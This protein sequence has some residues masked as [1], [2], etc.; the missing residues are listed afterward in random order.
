MSRS[1]CLLVVIVLCGI[2]VGCIPVPKKTVAHYG[3]E[4]RLTD[5]ATGAPIAKSRVSI[6]VDG[7]EFKKKTNPR[8]EF[9]VAFDMHHFCT[10]LGGP[11]WADATRA[12]VDIAIDGYTPYQRTFVVRSESLDVPLPPDQGRL[13]ES[14]VMLGEIEMKRREQV[15]APS[16]APLRR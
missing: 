13:K 16:V 1:T 9:K 12:A 15:T 7:Q 11:W 8:W 4:G 3:V 14:F 6:W 10:W 2:A 5:A